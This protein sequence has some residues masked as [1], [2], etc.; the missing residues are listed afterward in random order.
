MRI[1]SPIDLSTDIKIQPLHFHLKNNILYLIINT[2]LSVSLILVIF[3]NTGS[4]G[5]TLKSSSK[6]FYYS[7]FDL[8][9]NLKNAEDFTFSFCRLLLN[10]Y[11]ALN[12][13]WISI[14]TSKLHE[15]DPRR[16]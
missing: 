2:I 16:E 5:I 10:M 8:L 15:T 3:L 1:A 14:A 9:T 6:A 13:E 7:S 12:F 11:L 4:T